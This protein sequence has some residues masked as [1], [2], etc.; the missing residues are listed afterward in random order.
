MISQR[1]ILILLVLIALLLRVLCSVSP[2]S[3]YSSPPLYG[4]YEAQR[5]WMEITTNLNINDW[6]RNTTQNDLLY[7]GLDYPPLTAYT[8][9]FIGKI[10][11]FFHPQ[12]VE[13][14]ESRGYESPET[15]LFMRLSVIA[16]DVAVFFP[17]IL[18]FYYAALKTP[19]F[20][21]NYAD[22]LNIFISP[23][24]ILTDHGHF[25]Y[26]NISLGLALCGIAQFIL[27]SARNK[28]KPPRLVEFYEFLGC[29]SFVCSLMF[30][31]MSLY[32]A[33]AFF[34]YLLGK[35][36]RENRGK[37]FDFFLSVALL[38]LIVL[39]TIAILLLPF[40]LAGEFSISSITNSILAIITRV[41]PFN[42]GLYEDKVANFW[43]SSGLL[44]KWT[45]FF[46]SS[47]LIRLSLLLTLASL[48]PSGLNLV[49]FPRLPNFLLSLVNSAFAFYLFSFQVHE[50]TILLPLLPLILLP[51]IGTN[52]ENQQ[53]YAGLALWA[54]FIATFSMFPLLYRDNLAMIYFILQFLFIFLNIPLIFTAFS[55]QFRRIFFFSLLL[56]AAIHIYFYLGPDLAR[57]PDLKVYF[58]TLSSFGHFVAFLVA[59]NWAQWKLETEERKSKTQ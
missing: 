50:K 51:F 18:L 27:S 54:Q 53:F 39:G 40:I 10:A 46:Q 8:S 2:Y 11:Q 36:W 26:N 23:A 20:S 25:Q 37:P 56:C 22:L 47:L 30:K 49:L 16:A 31:Q 33:P 4:D 44:I 9:Y 21:T 41:F 38:G 48:L 52:A 24:L 57:L 19:N 42:R 58:F 12:L 43:C 1:N 35:K 13:L 28:Q 34:F 29:V 45:K 32:Y 6:Y 15:K 14:H 7:W 17:A 59:T 3:G 5:H 55:A